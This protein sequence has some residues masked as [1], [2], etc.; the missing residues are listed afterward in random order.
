MS[1]GFKVITSSSRKID[2][3]S[4][5]KN[6]TSIANSLR[7]MRLKMQEFM[8]D[9]KP[10]NIAN[11]KFLLYSW[12]DLKKLSTVTISNTSSSVGGV[13]TY[14]PDSVLL[15][16]SSSHSVCK[17]CH[18]DID[19]CPGHLGLIEFKEPI[20]HPGSFQSRDPTYR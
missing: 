2:D 16:T 9:R 17:T 10:A 18:S 5:R 15:G 4:I 7:N 1:S 19:I 6:Q 12:E 14:T 3:N 13:M 20:V 8:R 11:V